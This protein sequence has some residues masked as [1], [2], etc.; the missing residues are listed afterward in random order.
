M[1]ESLLRW[2][3]EAD[4]ARHLGFL[5]ANPQPHPTTD[6]DR[7]LG[8]LYISLVGELFELMREEEEA[9]TDYALVG[10]ALVDISDAGRSSVVVEEVSK[11][12]AR[13]FGAAAFYFGGYPASAY[14]SVRGFDSNDTDDSLQGCIDLLRRRSTPRSG[15]V[16]RLL[17]AL[18]R[19]NE[20]EIGL[21]VSETE[22]RSTVALS[23]GPTEWIQA[24]LFEQLVHR[25]ASTNLR[26]VLP[27]G[28]NDRWT[29]LVESLVNRTP[30]AWEFF[31]SQIQAISAGLLTR[32]ETFSLQ[33]P[34]GAGKTA[35]CETLL[36]AHARDFADSVAILLVPYRSLASELRSSVVRRLN[37]MGIVAGCVY[38]G[39]VPTGT[40]VRGLE[41]I[42]SLV[43][44]P[45]AL[46]G[47]LSAN[48]TFAQ[49]ISLV[50][51]DEGH[52]LDGGSRGVGLELL[53]A[54]LRARPEPRP[55]CVFVSA[56][57][58]NIEE[59]NAWLGGTSDSVVRSDYRAAI[60]EFSVLRASG[61]GASTSIAL[62]LHPHESA[63]IKFQI[64]DFLPSR[65]FLF[66]N[67]T[68][69]RA[70]TYT[71]TSLK[72]QS[73][74]AARKVLSLGAVAV[75]AANKKGN[76]GAI[77][78]A[79]ELLKQLAANISLP[80]PIEF[81]S[82]EAIG[83]AVD[84]LRREF[85]GDWIGTMLLAAGAILHHGD[86][87]QEAREVLEDLLRHG[88]VSFAICTST[89][90]E[91]V[92]LPIRTLVLYSVRRVHKSGQQENL[93]TRDI[94]N[95]VGR[96][97]RAGSTTKGLV[98]CANS[99]QWPLIERVAKQAPGESVRGAL[100]SLV[101]DLARRLA[102][103]ATSLTNDLL[104]Q[105]PDLQSLV[106]GVDA[107][108]ID[109][110]ASEIG[111]GELVAV[112]ER[113]ASET[114]AARQGD[115]IA[116]ELL[117]QVFGLRARR[118]ASLAASGRL[119]WIQ[120][121]GTR[122]RSLASVEEGLLPLVSDWTV[123]RNPS[124]PEFVSL[125]VDWALLQPEVRYRVSEFFD[126]RDD[127]ATISPRLAVIQHVQA[128]VSG[129]SFSEIA[130]LLSLSVDDVLQLN[131]TVVAY[132]LQAAVEQGIALLKSI[133]ESRGQALSDDVVDFPQ[134]L[135]FGLASRSACTLS[136]FGVRH[137]RASFELAKVVERT[138]VGATD[139]SSVVALARI[140][141]RTD[142]EQ[143]R[144]VLGSF[145][146]QR[147]TEDLAEPNR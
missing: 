114:L 1:R 56:I 119:E 53:L 67:P 50:I 22:E 103:Q 80:V 146:F 92:N 140:A 23:E 26:S 69:G 97:G 107:T 138:A 84:Y 115:G 34:T 6:A 11:D 19:G 133:L 86:I 85:G 96:A 117:R 62:E 104:E 94:K 4:R 106:D 66:T 36:F 101:D 30:P 42:Q 88:K 142:A 52:L 17:G 123:P 33:M 132:Q 99:E 125:V 128:W 75:F 58:P 145:V 59:I 55:R 18:L 131:S 81:A 57:V 20:A 136:A 122:V 9:S 63:P 21:V 60:A 39:T 82:E 40:E 93:L 130:I 91:G 143:L 112:A 47:V 77:G 70:N 43:A 90:A 61:T 78:L 32:R 95:L 3:A 79:G 134:M 109:L 16:R 68:T 127:L 110:A 102:I 31:P 126:G 74:A 13:L 72:S 98:I 64:G 111:E 76:R 46:A 24:R 25:F 12:D 118:I 105:S 135:R 37:E 144:A 54:R 7:R 51:C 137:R 87:P 5:D 10:N 116:T 71:H 108:L 139:P 2:V 89:L 38:G 124:S 14:L 129:A 141:L 113:I 35:M 45:E 48:P 121:S 120:K 49:R 100:I 41:E 73:I 65:S 83:P 15:A 147:S 8:D 27:E 44:T 29:S 28:F